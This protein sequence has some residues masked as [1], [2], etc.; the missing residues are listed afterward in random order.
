MMVKLFKVELAAVMGAD[1]EASARGPPP[2]TSQGS[3]SKSLIP[4]IDYLSIIV[5]IILHFL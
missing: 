5:S 2:L 3:Q 4:I 1:T